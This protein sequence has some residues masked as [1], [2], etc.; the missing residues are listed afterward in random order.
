MKQKT[1]LLV[2]ALS[3]AAVLGG[4]R[5]A[6]P[7]EPIPTG[8]AAAQALSAYRD[9]LKAAPAIEGEHGELADASFDYEQNLMMFGSHYDMFALSD[10][11]QDGIP[12]LIAQSTVNF[13]WAPV[14]VY[15]YADGKAVLLTDPLDA[16]A[17]GTFEQR[18]T[19][20]GAYLTY[21]CEENHIHSVWRGTNPMGEAVEENRAYALAGTALSAVDCT[22]GENE[23]TVY[24][25][26]IAKKNTAA[27]AEAIIQ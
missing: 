26:D 15:T 13:R 24:F 2:C 16:Q 20:N 18:S 27:N 25:S 1:I 23:H 22:A 10:L 3:L 19:A 6:S 14:S 7:T 8:N 11:D 5:M 12:E 9:I 17:H 4:C 21:L